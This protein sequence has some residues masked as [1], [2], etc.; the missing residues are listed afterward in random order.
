MFKAAMIMF[1]LGVSAAAQAACVIHVDQ[2]D[3]LFKENNR[4]FGA[5][6]VQ[7]LHDLTDD[8]LKDLG[9]QTVYDSTGIEP[10]HSL[11][12]QYMRSTA[13]ATSIKPAPVNHQVIM[14]W[15]DKRTAETKIFQ[16]A[17]L[18]LESRR[19]KKIREAKEYL[20]DLAEEHYFTALKRLPPCPSK[21]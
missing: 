1:T 18:P 15:G 9:Y 8:T 6:N 3:W 12:L 7:I 11:S 4:G 14:I 16:I 21:D 2:L 13:L 17:R 10:T 20:L 19:P 5:A